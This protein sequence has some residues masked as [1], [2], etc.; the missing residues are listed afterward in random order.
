MRLI[1][2]TLRAK[3]AYWSYAAAIFAG[4]A[5]YAL[6]EKLQADGQFPDH[7]IETWHI[8]L[9]T[10]IAYTVVKRLTRSAWDKSFAFIGDQTRK[11]LAAFRNKP[12]I[13]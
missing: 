6:G 12:K 4:G 2:M 10:A 7:P 8:W 13:D 11:S 5:V 9:A 1:R 3:R